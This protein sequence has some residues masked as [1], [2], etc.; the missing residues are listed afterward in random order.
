MIRL[1][2]FLLLLPLTACAGDREA[3]AQAPL[4]DHI[5]TV[6][7]LDGAPIAGD[8]ASAPTLRIADGS[9]SASGGVNRVNG[10][11]TVTGDHLEV[12]KLISTRR[13]GPPELMRQEAAFSRA[14]GA[15]RTWAVVD[16][17]LRLHDAD[18]AERIRAR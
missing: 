18:G 8:A 11:C 3:P 15:I 1:F 10:S 6:T 14:L 13:A 17:E 5:W 16:G 4:P 12:G 7:V 9:L 2:L